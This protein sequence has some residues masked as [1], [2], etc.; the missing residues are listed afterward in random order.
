MNSQVACSTDGPEAVPTAV[1]RIAGVTESE[2]NAARGE[3]RL[4]PEVTA[5]QMAWLT[6]GQHIGYLAR[7]DDGEVVY[8]VQGLV[9]ED[10]QFPWQ[11]LNPD[12]YWTGNPE[13]DLPS[14][15]AP[16]QPG[17]M[18]HSEVMQNFVVDE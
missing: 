12:S 2:I 6:G 13:D 4:N 18:T 5:G 16:V 10:D 9:P 1:Y 14:P 15:N 17:E 7:K 8:T 3:L 11:S